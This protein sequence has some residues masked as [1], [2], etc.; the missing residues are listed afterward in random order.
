M[1]QEP[2]PPGAADPPAG[3]P[4]DAA[5]LRRAERKLAPRLLPVVALSALLAS[6]NRSAT[7]LAS[8]ELTAAL[9]L[10]P[11]AYAL[12]VSLFCVPYCLLQV[13]SQMAMGAM[14][15]QNLWLAALL[16]CWGATAASMA[17]VRTRWEFYAMRLL[18]GAFEAGAAPGLWAYLAH[19]YSKERIVMPLAVMMGSLILSQ[20]IGPLLAAGLL[21]MGGVGGLRGWQWLF[22]IEG[23][24]AVAVA[25]AWVFM[26]RDVEAVTALTPEELAAVRASFASTQP[27]ARGGNQLA[28]LRRALAN[29]AVAAVSC[30]RFLRDAA[31][32]G[33]LAF[34]PLLL[35]NLMGLEAPGAEPVTK[36]QN[37]RIVLLI[38]A[39]FTA[40]V[41]A[42]F[43]IAWSSQRRGERRFHVAAAWGVGAAGLLAL[44]FAI[45]TFGAAFACL[46]VALT[47]MVAGEG[48]AVAHFMALQGGE[49]GVGLAIINSMGGVG[50]FVGP[51][52]MGSLRERTGGYAAA[53]LVLAG[54]QAL[55]AVGVAALSPSRA[56]RW[57]RRERG[58]ATRGGG[59]G[60]AAAEPAAEAGLAGKKSVGGPSKS[61]VRVHVEA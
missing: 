5:A 29:P 53:L 48:A 15:R 22:L 14:R 43:A 13:P 57:A 38:A 27:P 55:A 59:D 45:G 33:L 60:E 56:E 21:A 24:S 42:Q 9:G 8:V 49:K 10:S 41:A 35:K 19:F 50:E 26:P 11:T 52:V 46:S 39:P 28:V 20:I 58:G 2:Q 12:G 7:A 37:V 3:P 6:L 32:Y 31:L 17:A 16:V 34:M 61:F 54:L 4:A 44:P 51:V 25:F 36:A 18:L 47:G 40:A 1:E 23:L 30:I